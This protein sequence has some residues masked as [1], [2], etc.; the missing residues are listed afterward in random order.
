MKLE[1]QFM[2]RNQVWVNVYKTDDDKLVETA[3]Y[4]G[5]DYAEN[6]ISVSNQ[7]GCPV[8]CGFCLVG[9]EGFSRDITV[10]E[11]VEQVQ[12][13]LADAR[14]FEPD[15][16]IK[17]SFTRAGEPL[18][19]PNTP[20]ALEE[21]AKR[22]A[23]KFKFTSVMPNTPTALKNIEEMKAFLKEYD[24]EFQF[25][26]SMHTSDELLRGQ[27]IPYNNLMSFREIAQFGEQWVKALPSRKV[28]L[29]F[30]LMEKNPFDM[31]DI[32]RI[33]S[34]D[35]FAI[36]FSLYLPCTY[37]QRDRYLPSPEERMQALAMSARGFGYLCIESVAKETERTW[38]TSPGSGKLLYRGEF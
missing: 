19:N 36:R 2:F 10:E 14:L 18:L 23:P 34:P 7:I 30:V 38:H 11:Y 26:V 25:N 9:R 32:K 12:R 8:G 3:I 28:N 16:P 31:R 27:V 15:K 21:L 22:F 29:S 6:L 5:R 1:A 4:S 20:Q 33:F 37:R 17:V 35:Y 13:V 24:N